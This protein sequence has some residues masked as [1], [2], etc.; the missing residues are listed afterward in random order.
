[1]NHASLSHSEGS[2]RLG[3][4]CKPFRSPLPS[5]Q[6]PGVTYGS[7]RGNNLSLHPWL[8]GK[9]ILGVSCSKSKEL[10]NRQDDKKVRM[11]V[12]GEVVVSPSPGWAGSATGQEDGGWDLWSAPSPGTH[13][14]VQA[15]DV[16]MKWFCCSLRLLSHKFPSSD[17]TSSIWFWQENAYFGGEKMKGKEKEKKNPGFALHND[18]RYPANKN[19]NPEMD[20][21]LFPH[22]SKYKVWIAAPNSHLEGKL[23]P[24]AGV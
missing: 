3:L 22:F 4:P 6:L 2:G 9:T 14:S 10:S 1:M 17:P 23:Q 12:P 20:L 16:M 11:G 8:A 13:T 19:T 7:K 21:V 15:K 5:L 24:R 18:T